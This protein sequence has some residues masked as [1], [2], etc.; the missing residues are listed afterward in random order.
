DAV[1]AYFTYTS[2]DG[3]EGYPGKLN[4]MVLYTLTAAN[5]LYIMYQ[6]KTDKPTPVNLTN[7]SYFN[8]A[9]QGSGDILG[10]E[11]MI[12]ADKYT[13][14][15]ATLIPTGKIEPVEGTPLDFRK[16]KPI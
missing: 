13:P 14:T 12:A 11:L 10:H 3:E 4:V 8:L 7:H 16:P 9:G 2:K 5:E 6:A 15:D 1:S